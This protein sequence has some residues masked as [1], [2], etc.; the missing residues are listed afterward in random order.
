MG[1]KRVPQSLVFWVTKIDK[2][3][4]S[5]IDS[6]IPIIISKHTAALF[7]NFLTVFDELMLQKIT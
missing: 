2:E 1:P 5:D 3:Q 4:S 6:T 7:P